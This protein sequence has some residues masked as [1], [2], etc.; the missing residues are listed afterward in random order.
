MKKKVCRYKTKVRKA[1]DKNIRIKCFW[2]FLQ[3]YEDIDLNIN[4][5]T[6]DMYTHFLTYTVKRKKTSIFQND[7]QYCKKHHVVLHTFLL[8]LETPFKTR[9]YRT[10]RT[11]TVL[12]KTVG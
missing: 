10:L 1:E 6:S 7:I 5:L 11:Q 8:E 9:K 4:T 3:K 2:N 12:L